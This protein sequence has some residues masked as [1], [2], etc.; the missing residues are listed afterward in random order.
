MN[1][2]RLLKNRSVYEMVTKNGG[3]AS[4][5]NIWHKEGTCMLGS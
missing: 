2:I 4:L 5:N 1:D 3:S